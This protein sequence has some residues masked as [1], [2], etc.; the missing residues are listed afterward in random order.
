[1]VA[2]RC[3]YCGR[4][5]EDE[6]DMVV[7]DIKGFLALHGEQRVSFHS[8]FWRERYRKKRRENILTIAALIAL[9]IFLFFVLPILLTALRSSI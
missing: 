2:V 5:I 3:Y 1:M 6:N 7:K 8:A 9:P 4:L